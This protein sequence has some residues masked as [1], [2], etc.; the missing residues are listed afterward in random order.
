MGNV[1]VTEI[2]RHWCWPITDER[3]F[4]SSLTGWRWPLCPTHQHCAQVRRMPQHDEPA[5]GDTTTS[6]ETCASR[7]YDINIQK[8]HR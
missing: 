1:T 3:T 2:W 7:A 6:E 5:F 4:V 8:L